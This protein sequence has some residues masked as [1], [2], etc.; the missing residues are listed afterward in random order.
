MTDGVQRVFGMEYRP[1]PNK[2]LEAQA[3]AGFKVCLL[4]LGAFLYSFL[5]PITS[6]ALRKSVRAR[7]QTRIHIQYLA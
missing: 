6:P 7:G 3:P 4:F 2:I 1:I 5:N